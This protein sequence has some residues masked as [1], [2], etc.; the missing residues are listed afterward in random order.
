MK[1]LILSVSKI[2]I[3]KK[4][5]IYIKYDDKACILNKGLQFLT[6]ICEVGYYPHFVDEKTK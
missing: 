2:S 6:H 3:K 5:G 1:I 4:E